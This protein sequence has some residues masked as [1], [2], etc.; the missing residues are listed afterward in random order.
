LRRVRDGTSNR[1][2]FGSRS[3]KGTGT[4]L[5]GRPYCPGRPLS[6]EDRGRIIELHKNGKKV[7]AISK[8][9]CISHGC[10][11]KIIS[12]VEPGAAS[13]KKDKK[14]FTSSAPLSAI[15]GSNL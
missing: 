8:E 5:Y 4:N 10:V 2:R 6:M 14:K 9:L 1:K 11:S 15:D 13:P 12:S 3:N 7:N